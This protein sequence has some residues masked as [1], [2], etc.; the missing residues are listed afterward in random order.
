MLGRDFWLAAGR[1]AAASAIMAGAVFAVSS[2]VPAPGSWWMHLAVLLLLCVVGGMVYPVA[3][4]MLGCHELGWLL[5][6]N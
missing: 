5:R 1:I 3:A 2:V 6:R 4:R